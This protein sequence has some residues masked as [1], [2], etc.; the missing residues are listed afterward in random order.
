MKRHHFLPLLLTVLAL[1]TVLPAAA[2]SSR[3]ITASR[4][5]SAYIFQVFDSAADLRERSLYDS[6]THVGN[7][8]LLQSLRLKDSFLVAMSC[9]N[10]GQTAQSANHKQ[11]ALAFFQR[12]LSARLEKDQ[13]A[14]TAGVYN[15]LGYLHGTMG[16]LDIQRDWYLKA[17]RLY[18]R[19]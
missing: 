8:A 10:L 4:Q 1:S 18:N 13:S 7:R 19:N 12:A 2:Q 15:D 6:A 11:A 9:Y 17:M 14:G 16:E 3:S 5:D